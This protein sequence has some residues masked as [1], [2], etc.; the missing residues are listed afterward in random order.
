[1]LKKQVFGSMAALLALSGCGAAERN[2]Y[3]APVDEVKSKLIG[4]Q[5]SYKQGDQKRYL[6]VTGA[7]ARS[8]SVTMWND[9]S[10]KK[11]CSIKLE[12]VDASTT[13]LVPSCGSTTS[14]TG[15]TALGFVENEV[16][17]HAKQI[18]T[19]EPVDVAFLRNSGVASVAKNLPAMQ[20][21]ALAADAAM[22]GMKEQVEKAEAANAGWGGDSEPARGSGGDDWGGK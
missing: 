22:R 6:K 11:N 17:E 7:S 2:T 21:E 5:S 12:E 3:S 20:G 8:V 9:V 19:G 14:A 16:A 15:A 4:K 13:K 1:M 10:W 18:L